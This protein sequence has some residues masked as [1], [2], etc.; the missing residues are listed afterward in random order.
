[1]VD[2]AAD[3]ALL[4]N[5]KVGNPLGTGIGVGLTGSVDETGASFS[6]ANATCQ[7][8]FPIEMLIGT[9]AGAGIEELF[10][11]VDVDDGNIVVELSEVEVGSEKETA[12]AI[13][14][15]GEVGLHASGACHGDE[16]FRDLVIA[17]TLARPD[18]VGVV[19]V[20]EAL[21]LFFCARVFAGEV[22]IFELHDGGVDLAE[23]LVLGVGLA[24]RDRGR[25]R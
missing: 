22:R 10:F 14:D 20:L 23:L 9:V 25:R 8:M 15:G 17:A 6:L 24:R 4:V 13:G 21:R 18:V 16:E 3:S 19:D 7:G 5:N 1:M 12:I 2:D 11:A